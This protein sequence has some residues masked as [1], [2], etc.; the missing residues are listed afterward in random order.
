MADRSQCGLEE[1]K[2]FIEGEIEKNFDK[3]AE[4]IKW[5]FINF[6]FWLPSVPVLLVFA[7]NID[8]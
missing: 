1:R 5:E 8:F 3:C 4:D 7:P 2:N 6:I